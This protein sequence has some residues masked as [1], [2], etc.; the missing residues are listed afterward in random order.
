MICCH[1]MLLDEMQCCVI[2][3]TVKMSCFYFF[4]VFPF[5]C[6]VVLQSAQ[7]EHIQIYRY[8]Y[9]VSDPFEFAVFYRVSYAF[10]FHLSL[11]CECP[12]HAGNY[13]SLLHTLNSVFTHKKLC[14]RTRERLFLIAATL[15]IV[16]NHQLVLFSRKRCDIKLHCQLSVDV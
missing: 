9:H 12:I 15:E 5:W 8:F 14:A 7:S 2:I 4:H 6:N 16:C 10:G 1:E 13:T 11:P 3:F